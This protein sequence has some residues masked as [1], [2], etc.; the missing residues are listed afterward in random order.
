MADGRLYIGVIT[1]FTEGTYHGKLINGIHSF[2]KDKNIRVFVF[3]TYMISRFFTDVKKVENYYSLAFNHIDGWIILTESASDNHINAIIKS[4]KPVIF[5]GINKEINNCTIIKSDN[6]FGAIQSVEHLIMH[7]HRKIAFVGWMEL[8]DMKERFE[9]YKNALIKNGLPYDEN[10]V[11]RTEYSLPRD[12]KESVKWWINKGIKFTAIF[13]GNDAIAAGAIKELEGYGLS[14]PDDVAV[15]GCDNSPFALRNS[16]GITTIDQNIYDL[17]YIAAQNLIDEIKDKS[18]QGRTIMTKSNLVLR[19]SCGCNIY[20]EDEIVLTKEDLYK[21]DEIIK[22]LEDAILKNSDIGTRLLTTDIEG[23]KKL[24]PYMVDNYY[25]ECIGFKDDDKSGDGRLKI[26]ALYDMSKNEKNVD[27]YCS[28]EDFPPLQLIPEEIHS[29]SD[30]IIWIIPISSTTKNWGV[31]AYISP[32]NETSAMIKYNVF[33]VITTLLGIAMD[34]DVAKTELEVA[35]ESL[36]QTHNQLIQSEKTA[37]LGGLVAGV[38][39]EVNTPIGVSVTAASYL[40]EKNREIME[41]LE[42]SKLKK[43]DMEKYIN[44]TLETINILMIN[45]ERASKLVKS[46]KQVAVDQSTE[47]KRIFLIKDHIN[48]V[49]LSLN[50]KIKKTKHKILFDCDDN[51]KIYASLGG[52]SQIITNLFMNSLIHAF[53]DKEEGIIFIHVLKEFD[54]IIIEYSDNGKGINENDIRKIYEPFFTTKRGNG[55]TGLG[56]NIVYNIVVN[57]YKGSIKCK[58]SPGNGATFIIRIPVNE[59]DC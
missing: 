40:D 4:N 12:G 58:S 28:M 11:Y 18:L 44:T 59:V 2:T 22:Y 21:K 56:L 36:K 29:N 49:L 23:I 3:N 51:L 5:I 37:A 43:V 42:S 57:E 50:P 19:K 52:L 15:I 10:L 31:I 47:G 35:L 13:A 55:G 17:G 38:A 34:R 25:W 14:V 54:E 30:D 27:L 24:F 45:L 46:F 26:K 20:V 48:D 1:K 53:E 32:F 16:L 41:L 33:I 8:D 7:G 9:G 6:I 39:H